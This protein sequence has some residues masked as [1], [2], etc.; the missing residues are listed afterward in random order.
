MTGAELDAICRDY[1]SQKGFGKYFIHSTGHGIG[2]EIH[3]LPVIAPK[4]NAPLPVGSVIT[5]EPG[6]YI[7]NLGGARIE[8]SLVLTAKG[9]INL[10]KMVS[11]KLLVL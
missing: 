8:D 7:P 1:I 6:I 9:A 10:S 11:K 5:C 2:M 3:E 4:H